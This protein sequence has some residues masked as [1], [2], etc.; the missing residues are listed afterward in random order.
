MRL[1]YQNLPTEHLRFTCL[2]VTMWFI[3]AQNLGLAPRDYI[4]ASPVDAVG[5]LQRR[6][7]T[8]KTALGF[9]QPLLIDSHSRPVVDP[10]W[11][12]WPITLDR[13]GPKPCW[14]N[15]QRRAAWPTCAQR[16]VRA[17]G[18]CWPAMTHASPISRAPTTRSQGPPEGCACRWRSGDHP[19]MT[20]TVTIVTPSLICSTCTA[21]FP[22]VSRSYRHAE[23]PTVGPCYVRAH[24]RPSVDD[25]INGA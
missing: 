16:P 5:E 4:D 8:K 21:L 24:R 20:S 19:L 25:A 6:R 2:D 22:L 3:S 1:F 14:W 17:R 11:I 18:C 13:T 12:C 7:P 23:F 9:N 10:V 15:G